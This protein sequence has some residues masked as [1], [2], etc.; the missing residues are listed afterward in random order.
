MDKYIK[1]LYQLL[2][3]FRGKIPE[4]KL[5]SVQE[6]IEHNENGVALDLF[7]DLIIEFN[8]IVESSSYESLVLLGNQMHIDVESILNK[9]GKP[10]I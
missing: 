6:Y 7:V 5:S 2:D 1:I 8:C 4:D 3:D 10:D 9:F